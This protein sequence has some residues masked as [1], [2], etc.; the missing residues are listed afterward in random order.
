MFIEGPVTKRFAIPA[1][2]EI[3]DVFLDAGWNTN[4]PWFQDT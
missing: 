3:E 2:L 1:N 4:V